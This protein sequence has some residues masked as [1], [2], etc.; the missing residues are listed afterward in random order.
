MRDSTT[1]NRKVFMKPE[2]VE[3][4]YKSGWHAMIAMV[5]LYEYKTHKSL[6]SKILAI[7]LIA[8]HTD[9]AVCDYLGIPTTPQRSIKRMLDKRTGI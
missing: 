4:L 9:A 2:H 8:F 7:G 3:K 6:L 1:K 5:G